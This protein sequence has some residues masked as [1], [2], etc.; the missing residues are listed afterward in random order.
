MGVFMNKSFSEI[1]EDVLK[2]LETKNRNV[3]ELIRSNYELITTQLFPVVKRAKLNRAKVLLELVIE[4]GGDKVTEKYISLALYRIRVERGELSDR[5][6][7]K[8][9]LKGVKPHTPGIST[10]SKVN[11]VAASDVNNAGNIK[12]SVDM[13]IGAK[14]V[15]NTPTSDIIQSNGAQAQSGFDIRPEVINSIKIKLDDFDIDK[16]SEISRLKTE[17]LEKN[18]V[19]LVF[20]EQDRVILIY[21][22]N[23]AFKLHKNLTNL[24]LAIEDYQTATKELLQY[25][26]A[27][28]QFMR[29][30]ITGYGKSIN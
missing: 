25:F 22:T 30:D 21:F 18:E 1:L 6:K 4:A 8:L 20:T 5:Q 11:G 13:G 26:K 29:I 19:P 24:Y 3:A 27:K 12:N 9:M 10:V 16:Q 14:T 7:R 17:V 28:C 23:Y 2:D 15:Y